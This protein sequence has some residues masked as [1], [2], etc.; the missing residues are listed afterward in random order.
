VLV[1]KVCKR[2]REKKTREKGSRGGGEEIRLSVAQKLWPEFSPPPKGEENGPPSSGKRRDHFSGVGGKEKGGKKRQEA[3]KVILLK[4][5]LLGGKKRKA[6]ERKEFHGFKRRD[7][8][9]ILGNCFLVDDRIVC[10]CQKRTYLSGGG[11]KKRKGME[12]ADW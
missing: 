6:G 4:R 9:G 12:M 1:S 11:K 2:G 5:G 3:I 7:R 10:L 8:L